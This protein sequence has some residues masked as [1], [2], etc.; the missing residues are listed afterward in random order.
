MYFG[1]EP[2]TSALSGA[3]ITPRIASMK[4]ELLRQTYR[5]EDKIKGPILPK[6]AVRWIDQIDTF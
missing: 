4:I 5:Q 1:F 3:S 6:M 2:A